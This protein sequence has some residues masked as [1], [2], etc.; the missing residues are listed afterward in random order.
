M[1]NT[2]RTTTWE[3]YDLELMPIPENLEIPTF[4]EVITPEFSKEQI[5][6]KEQKDNGIKVSSVCLPKRFLN[7]EENQTDL[8]DFFNS[9]PSPK[10]IEIKTKFE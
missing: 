9:L 5:F 4:E 3:S 10:I 2:Q 8:N 6:V 7:A 1:K